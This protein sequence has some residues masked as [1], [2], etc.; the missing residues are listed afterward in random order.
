MFQEGLWLGR[1]PPGLL[2]GE[3]ALL[4][5]P[6]RVCWFLKQIRLGQAH[7]RSKEILFFYTTQQGLYPHRGQDG[8]PLT[9]PESIPQDTGPSGYSGSKVAP[10]NF[11][12]EICM[13][14]F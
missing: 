13:D 7:C 11:L 4:G 12:P 6:P 3:P 2:A 9:C 1:L 5:D 14:T 10:A 8:W